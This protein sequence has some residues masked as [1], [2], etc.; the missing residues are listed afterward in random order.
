MRKCL[1]LALPA[2]LLTTPAASSAQISLP[3][4]Q[5]PARLVAPFAFVAVNGQCTD[6]SA[7]ITPLAGVPGWNLTSHLTLAGSAIDLHVL[8]NPDPSVTFGGTTVNP[9]S[10]TTS[11]A[12]LFG[13]PIV[14][15]FYST[16]NSTLRLTLTSPTGTTTVANSTTYPTFVSGYGT[17]GDELTNLGVDLGATPCTAS[18]T[19]ATGTCDLGSAS[20]TFTPTYY[21][22]LEA[23]L[24]YTQ[25]NAAST[26]T[27]SGDVTLDRTDVVTTT[28]EPATFTL[29]GLGLG[30]LALGA[31]R[32]R[33]RQ[34]L[35]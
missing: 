32:R 11:Y 26:V 31:T 22:N 1:L 20:N 29:V 33:R 7:L 35:G 23:L 6:L 16:A 15:D 5:R 34:P 24:T 12:F 18:G 13:L 4:C 27:F 3:G 28:P 14:P 8:F 10:A 25:D 9:T 19:A 30:L 2:L 17:V 21:D